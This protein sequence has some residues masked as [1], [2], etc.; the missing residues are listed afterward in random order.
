MVQIGTPKPDGVTRPRPPPA[1]P[2]TD[3]QMS[4]GQCKQE[5]QTMSDDEC[6]TKTVVAT[7]Q[8]N[9]IVRDLKG[10]IIGR[11]YDVPF[12]KL[13]DS[14]EV[15]NHNEILRDNDFER[16]E[17]LKG[18]L[19]VRDSYA[20]RQLDL[21]KHMLVVGILVIVS[22]QMIVAAISWS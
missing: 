21:G 12:D 16:L 17:L 1:P 14:S 7:V 2:L 8:E 22:L 9:G 3:K 11:F 13:P 4:Y 20:S 15:L 5:R 18:D 6:K 10:T 19:K